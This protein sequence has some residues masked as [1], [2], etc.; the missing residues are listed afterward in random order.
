MTRRALILAVF[1][2]C[3]L[4]LAFGQS[5]VAYRTHFIGGH[6]YPDGSLGRALYEDFASRTNGR[7]RTTNQGWHWVWTNY[8][9]NV[10]A[11]IGWNTNS[12]LFKD[13]VLATGAS[14]CSPW[15]GVCNPS[16]GMDRVTM[17]TRRIGVSAGHYWGQ[18]SL[19]NPVT[20]TNLTAPGTLTFLGRSNT[21]HTNAIQALLGGTVLNWT[22]LST[23]APTEDRYYYLL[24]N[25]LPDAVETMRVI[26]PLP[27]IDTNWNYTGLFTDWLAAGDYSFPGLTVCQHGCVAPHNG[28]FH[29]EHS[30][31]TNPVA[32]HIPGDSGSPA[33]IIVSNEC[34]YT[35]G[36]TYAYASEDLVKAIHTINVWAGLDTNSPDNQL[37]YGPSLT[38]WP[39]WPYP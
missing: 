20:G 6:Y 36:W 31:S 10:P 22:L 9:P 33:F 3:L 16:F 21:L 27:T 25:N 18:Y 19:T 26:N 13:G 34:L 29:Y 2:F 24:S 11:P 35:G 1:T 17:L 8:N 4:P 39:A 37:R 5:F 14:A 23:N 15:N 38:N 12:L 30:G 7:G 32:W 28:F